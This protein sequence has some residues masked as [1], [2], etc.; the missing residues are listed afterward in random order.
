MTTD[1]KK[2]I[3]QIFLCEIMDEFERLEWKQG[4]EWNV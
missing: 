4:E 3:L 2:K 1:Y